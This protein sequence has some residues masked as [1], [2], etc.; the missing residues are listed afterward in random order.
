MRKGFAG[1]PRGAIAVVVAGLVLSAVAAL[2]TIDEDEGGARLDW[3]LHGD[4]AD[5]SSAPLGAEGS[6]EIRDAGIEATRDN[7]SGFGL[8]RIAGALVVDFGGYDGR[9][10]AHCTVR[11][12]P[13]SVLARTPGKR[14]AYPLPSDDLPSQAVP[15]LS[16]VRFNAKGTDIV[17]VEVEDAFD[18][19]TNADAA[20]VEWTPYRQ[21]EQGW[22]WVL[23]AGRRAEPVRLAFMTMWRTTGKP[24]AGIV[25]S[26]RAADEAARA[27]TSGKLG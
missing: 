14:A 4:I 27:A 10:E 21:G 22:A 5:S 9:A 20:K 18:D 17:G 8:F 11:V 12:P 24:G 15:E 6:L 19:F 16:V 23:P 7:A 3:E 2:L 1:I 26:A 13:G 25:C